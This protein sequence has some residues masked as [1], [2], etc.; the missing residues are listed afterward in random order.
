MKRVVLIFSLLMTMKT[1]ASQRDSLT[2]YSDTGYTFQVLN[3][4]LK[5]YDRVDGKLCYQMK[6]RQYDSSHT[7]LID[8]SESKICYSGKE[9]TM[10][11]KEDII[12]VHDTIMFYL[13]HSRKMAFFKKKPKGKS[14]LEYMNNPMA[15]LLKY[16]KDR[17]LKIRKLSENKDTYTY[18]VD[19]DFQK[20]MYVVTADKKTDYIQKVM[21][22]YFVPDEANLVSTRILKIDYTNYIFNKLKSENNLNEYIRLG[23]DKKYKLTEKYKDYK[24]HVYEN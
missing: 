4:I 23:I 21:I 15:F 18:S 20:D 5:V 19:F 10:E 7:V 12:I 14:E 8:S 11:Q 3:K 17:K 16:Y 6:M 2:L 24:L 1:Y 9:V 22:N 13:N